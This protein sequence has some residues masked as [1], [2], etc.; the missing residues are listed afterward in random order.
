MRIL[1]KEG[2]VY[3]LREPLV[4]KYGM[5]LYSRLEL[6]D[7]QVKY[8]LR[9]GI[10]SMHMQVR[11]RSGAVIRLHGVHPEPPAPTEADSSLPRDAELLIVG[12]D[13]KEH[14]TPTIVAGD[15]ND[16]AWSYTT[17]LFQ[18]ISSLLDPRKGRGM[19]NTFHAKIP[20]MRW[21]LDHV[22]HSRHFLLVDLQRLPAFG[23]DHFPVYVR[24][25]LKPEVGVSQESPPSDE[26]DEETARKKI[27]KAEKR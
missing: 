20:I 5:L 14:N 9:E 3:S 11:L 2:Y 17:G 1:E 21:S 6:L 16:V 23:S 18:K 24:L 8:L 25:L 15:L 26:E 13:V 27:K 22:F 10:P 4:N 19:F 12:R 7:P